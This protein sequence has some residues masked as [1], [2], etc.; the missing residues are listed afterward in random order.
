MDEQQTEI[1]SQIWQLLVRGGVDRRSPLHTPMVV[2]LTPDGKPDARVMVL[3]KAEPTPATLRF[4]T[5]SR[6][7][8]CAE[9]HGQP[10]AIL[11]YHAPEAIQL[12]IHGHGIVE[13]EGPAVDAA[14][15]ASSLFARRCYLATQPPGTILPAPGS[16]LP[17]EIEGQQPTDEQIAPAR[18]NFALVHIHIESIDWLHLANSGHR[19]A[20]FTFNAANWS[21]EWLAP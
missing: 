1:L 10:V 4:H 15:A 2:S 21:A 13:S 11:G 12:R 16:N 5:D 9:L 7:P 18:P 14:W 20:R 17:A 8:K 3:R 19:R 6:S